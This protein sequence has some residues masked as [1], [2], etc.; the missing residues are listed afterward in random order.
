[1]PHRVAVRLGAVARGVPEEA[2]FFLRLN[3]FRD[4]TRG[5]VAPQVLAVF[6]ARR[7]GRGVGVYLLD[8]LVGAVP[9]VA[10][11]E[12]QFTAGVQHRALCDALDRVEARF[13][14]AAQIE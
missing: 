3:G 14:Q 1:V 10:A 2:F 13:R 9:P 12:H 8:Y 5:V 7:C 11:L 6:L 4:L